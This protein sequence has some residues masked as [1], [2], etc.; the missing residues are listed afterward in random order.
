MGNKKYHA[1]ETVPK[2]NWKIIE[3]GKI[4]TFRLTHKYMTAN[5]T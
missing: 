5:C 1:V 4:D 3:K 2:S